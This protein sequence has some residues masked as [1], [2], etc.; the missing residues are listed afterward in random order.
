M[1]MPRPSPG[2]AGHVYVDPAT[3]ALSLTPRPGWDSIHALPGVHIVLAV[4]CQLHLRWHPAATVTDPLGPPEYLTRFEDFVRC[5]LAATSPT[6]AAW[7]A[8]WGQYRQKLDALRALPD[9]DHLTFPL[10]RLHTAGRALSPSDSPLPETLAALASM[11]LPG[12]P[13]RAPLGG[14]HAI[15]TATGAITALRQSDPLPPGHRL[16]SADS[17]WLLIHC[18]THGWEQVSSLHTLSTSAIMALHGFG[19]ALLAHASPTCDAL[20]VTME[21]LLKDLGALLE[22]APRSG[23]A[24]W[25]A[26]QRAYRDAAGAIA[27]A[28]GDDGYV[29][30]RALE[31]L[32]DW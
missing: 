28:L 12:D 17:P 9:A 31:T 18:A 13:P 7:R 21:I 30:A 27:R 10:R 2:P 32:A 14:R 29:V 15:D 26:T 4:S 19:S 16:L 20:R 8:A 24:Q 5:A 3:G 6:C 22:S 11:P 25:I 23:P 1:T